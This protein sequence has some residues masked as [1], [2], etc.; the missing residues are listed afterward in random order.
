MQDW[1]YGVHGVYDYVECLQCHI[2]QLDPFPTEELLKAAYEVDYHGY[3]SAQ[4]RGRLFRALSG[5][6]DWFLHR[7]IRRHLQPGCALLDVGCGSGAFLHKMRVLNPER[8][9]GIDFNAQ[10]AAMATARGVNV[11]LG[12]FST[13]SS[14]DQVYDAIFMNNYLEHVTDPLEELY[15]AFV[16]LKKGGVLLGEVPNFRSVDQRLF[17]RFWGGNHVPRHTFQFTADTL[18]E[19]LTRIGFESV[20]VEC[21]L[22]TSHL[23]LSIQNFLQ[24]K[25][26]DLRHNPA[27]IR[28]RARY[29][30]PLLIGM[31]P[32]NII[33][34]LL[35]RSGCMRFA[36]KVPGVP[37]SEVVSGRVGDQHGGG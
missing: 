29:Y 33:P 10:A 15:K 31:I 19:L 27:L 28:G 11:H 22:N 12:L 5:V 20:A 25:R 14:P 24:R 26:S 3:F 23:V 13:F 18:S 35:G 36:A 21:V 30:T 34:V 4:E 9:D 7:E 37:S 1:E 6:Q 2:V 16:L 17:G 8:L 32:F